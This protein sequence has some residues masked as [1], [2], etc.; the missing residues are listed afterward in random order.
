MLRIFAPTLVATPLGIRGGMRE[1]T[2]GLD[3]DDSMCVHAISGALQIEHQFSGEQLVVPENAEFF[4]AAGKLTPV[5]GAPGGCQC[6]SLEVSQSTPVIRPAPPPV[7]TAKPSG[8]VI[9]IPLPAGGARPASSSDNSAINAPS[10]Q[11]S[12]SARVTSK[13]SATADDPAPAQAFVVPPHANESHPLPPAT[14]NEAPPAPALNG[15]VYV[16][17][18]PALV[19]TSASPAPPKRPSVDTVLLAQQAQVQPAW[20]FKGQV[21]APE[22]VQAM[23]HSL[24]VSPAATQQKSPPPPEGKTVAA[25]Q[26][27]HGFW[28]GLKRLFAGES[29]NQE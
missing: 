10:P 23:Q 5:A 19:F 22:F 27:K 9:A 17:D 7:A 29:S 24:G 21:A 25:P 3:L 11:P 18:M 14:R 15:P 1:V 16:V 2:I 28:S 12:S 26:K 13:N 6:V 4:L 20:E 8:P